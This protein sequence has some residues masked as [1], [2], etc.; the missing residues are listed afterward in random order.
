MKE[1]NFYKIA[2]VI[3]ILLGVVSYAQVSAQEPIDRETVLSFDVE[4]TSTNGADTAFTVKID[5]AKAVSIVDSKVSYGT[6]S[7]YVVFR[8]PDAEDI[9]KGLGVAKAYTDTAISVIINNDKVSSYMDE[10][11]GLV[12]ADTVPIVE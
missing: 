1:L 7:T 8:L 12:E 5:K 4:L 6:K 9:K 11:R 10:I 3:L 2:F